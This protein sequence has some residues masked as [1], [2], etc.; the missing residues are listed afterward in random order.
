[1]SHTGTREDGDGFD[2]QLLAIRRYCTANNLAV[3]HVYRERGVSGTVDGMER[4]TWIEML[5]AIMANGVRVIV[6]ERLDRLARDLMIQEHIIAD[7]QRRGITLISAA[8]PD[9]CSADPSRKLLRQ[10]M[11]AIHEY[12]RAMVVLKLRGARQ[13]AKART[14]KCEGAKAFGHYP[15]E[16]TALQR[17]RELQAA[18]HPVTTIAKTLDAEGHKT[19]QGRAWQSRVLGRL[20]RAVQR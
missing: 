13:R 1:M 5:A 14:G 2:R 11:G 7:L 3:E 9:L 6:V 12:D 10:I 16:A 4:P 8:E 20:L 15:E 17:A 19:R 18:G